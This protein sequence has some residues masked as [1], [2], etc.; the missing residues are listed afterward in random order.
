MQVQRNNLPALKKSNPAKTG[1]FI[2]K[3]IG[4]SPLAFCFNEKSRGFH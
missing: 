2:E 4:V 3:L 1:F